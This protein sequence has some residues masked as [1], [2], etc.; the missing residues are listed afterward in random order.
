MR[1]VVLN[2]ST[3]VVTIVED[4]DPKEVAEKYNNDYEEYLIDRIN[5]NES[6]MDFMVGCDAIE[7]ITVSN[8][9][10]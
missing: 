3:S 9:K 8:L 6:T 1:I 2:Y 10:K 7:F 5:Y 4:V